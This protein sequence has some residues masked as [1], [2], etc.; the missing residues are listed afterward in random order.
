MFKKIALGAV[1][2]AMIASTGFAQESTN[3]VAAKTDWSVFV[4]EN[5]KKEC[6]AVSAPTKVV[7][8]RDGKVVN[9]K[10][11]QILLFVTY[12][13]GQQVGEVSFT[14]GYAFKADTPAT[15][16]IG[17]SSYNLFTKGENAWAA[18]PAEDAKIIESL[19]R[20]ASAVISAQSGRPTFTKDT[21]SLLGFTAA[22]AEAEKQCK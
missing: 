20:G 17:S 12:R 22:L 14:G 21:F 5:P 2:I 11:S 19:K 13:P 9:A 7:N 6:W 10:R 18:N 16:Q 3:R 4:E 8:T 1:S 15:V